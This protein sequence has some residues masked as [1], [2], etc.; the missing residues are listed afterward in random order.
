M[1]TIIDFIVAGIIL[2]TVV[3]MFI[4]KKEGPAKK[5]QIL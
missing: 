1:K 3:A 2:V 5:K 4:P